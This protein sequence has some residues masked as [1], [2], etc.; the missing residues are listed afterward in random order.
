M[1]YLTSLKKIQDEIIK[2]CS[3]TFTRNYIGGYF[4][5]W[6]KNDANT[7]IPNIYT[8]VFTNEYGNLDENTNLYTL[9]C[10][11]NLVY[12][13]NTITSLQKNMDLHTMLQYLE[14]FIKVQLN[15]FFNACENI[16]STCLSEDHPCDTP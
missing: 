16:D 4:E 13:I 10:G 7:E 1:A 15:D 5:I 6:M 9:G 3:D 2:D 12:H 14:V 11:S 8:S